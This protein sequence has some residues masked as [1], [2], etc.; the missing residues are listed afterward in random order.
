LFDLA[1]KLDYLAQQGLYRTRRIIDSPQGIN[2]SCNGKSVINF[3]SNDYLGLANHPAVINAFKQATDKYGVGSGSAHLICGHSSAHHALEEELAAFTGRDRTLLFSTGYMANM[4]LISALVGRGD[5]VLEDRL[6]HASLLDG[7]LLSGAKL[8]RYR[9]ADTD[10]LNTLLTKA[11][12]NNLIVT[13]GVFSMD[14]DFAPLQDLSTLTKQ[15]Q[16]WLMVD[17]A[18]GIG[19]LG[20]YGGGILEESGLAQDDVQVLVGTLGKA[21]GTFGA[22]VAGSDELIETLINT[23]RTYIYTTA[24]PA[25]I[26]EAT[27]SSL[28]LIQ[29]ESWRRDK[30]RNLSAQ[31]RA[32][33]SQLG[34]PLMASTSP[35]QP[36]LMGDSEK[37]VRISKLL[38]D[39]GFLV[40]AIRPPTVPANSARLRITFSAMH[41]EQ[42][43]DQLLDAIDKS[44][45]NS[46]QL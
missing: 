13:D 19:V 4:G 15:H 36:L 33:A 27:R 28:K 43:I 3:C 24:M 29:T 21:F 23:A 12:G 42:H 32:G 16:A 22:F 41:E 35:I 17:D 30:L 7:G 9:H 1:A 25:A 20:E 2:L 10:H 38:L 46:S 40:S 31:F 26:A 14:G 45:N 39:K 18:H 11:E 8:K 5:T 44:L 6:N 37:T 34:L